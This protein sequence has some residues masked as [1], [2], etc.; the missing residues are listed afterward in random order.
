MRRIFRAALIVA[1]CTF[2]VSLIYVELPYSF[3]DIRGADTTLP[4][5]ASVRLGDDVVIVEVADTVPER[6]KGLSGREGLAPY[7]GILFI[8]EDDGYPAIWMKDMRFAI[9]ILWIASD[10]V[11]V[12]IEEDVGPESYPSAFVPRKQARYVLELPDGYVRNNKIQL[13]DLARFDSAGLGF[14]TASSSEVFQSA[15]VQ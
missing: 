11:I 7:E 2:L 9:D 8:F 5:P 15:G 4:L 10:G 1:A 13:G 14:S 6:E 12:H 3:S